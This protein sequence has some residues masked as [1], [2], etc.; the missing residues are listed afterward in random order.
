MK[1]LELVGG[2]TYSDNAASQF[3]DAKLFDF[4]AL[5]SKFEAPKH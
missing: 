3:V 5:G 1:K 4:V 2:K